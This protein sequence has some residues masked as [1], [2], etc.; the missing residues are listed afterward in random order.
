MTASGSLGPKRWRHFQFKE[1]DSPDEPGSGINIDFELVDKL[2]AIREEC[3]F[4]FRITSGYRTPKHNAE[5]G[6][7]Y[8]S[9]HLTGHAADIAVSNSIER[10]MIVQSAIRHGIRRIGVKKDCVH[11]GNSFALPLDVLWTY[12]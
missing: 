8:N 4:P 11:L 6:G 12:D 5:V 1:F 2:D 9:D 3:G 10:F 7:K